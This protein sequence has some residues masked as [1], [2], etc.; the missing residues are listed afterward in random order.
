MNTLKRKLSEDEDVQD[1]NYAN[2]YDH[3]TYDEL[4]VNTIHPRYQAVDVVQSGKYGRYLN[5]F[6]RYREEVSDHI[7]IIIKLTPNENDL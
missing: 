2:N 5:D 6:K 7:P 4:R 1:D 3:F